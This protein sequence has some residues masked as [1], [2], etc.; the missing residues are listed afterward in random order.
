MPYLIIYVKFRKDGLSN[1]QVS[2][3]PTNEQ[4]LGEKRTCA[5]FQINI[6]RS[7][8]LI[9]VYTDGHDTIDSFVYLSD[10]SIWVF[11]V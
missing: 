1:K 7:E 10:V 8:G 9:R 2:A 11:C 6:S 4:L 5:K 3:I